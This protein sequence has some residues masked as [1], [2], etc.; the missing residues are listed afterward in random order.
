MADQINNLEPR[1]EWKYDI[2][3]QVAESPTLRNEVSLINE[4]ARFWI[5]LDLIR[6]QIENKESVLV[7][8]TSL[9]AVLYIYAKFM[10]KPDMLTELGK[11]DISDIDAMLRSKDAG[12]GVFEFT[13]WLWASKL[14]GGNRFAVNGIVDKSLT[15]EG[16][17]PEQ[18]AKEINDFAN[19]NTKWMI[20]KIVTPAD[21]RAAQSVIVNALYF[22]GAWQQQFDPKNTSTKPFTRFDWTKVDQEMMNRTLRLTPRFKASHYEAVQMNYKGG[23]KMIAILPGEW[24]SVSTV[25]NTLSTSWSEWLS[26][27][28]NPTAWSP[29]SKLEISF[30]KFTSETTLSDV[31]SRL[32]AAIWNQITGS[33]IVQ[34]TKIIVD[35]EWTTAAAVTG[36]VTRGFHLV[37]SIE[38]NKPFIYLLID[39]D[40]NVQF[41]WTYE[42][43][44][45]GKKL[46]V[47]WGSE[48]SIRSRH[49]PELD[50]KLGN[51]K[52]SVWNTSITFSG[53]PE[54]DRKIPFKEDWEFINIGNWKFFIEKATWVISFQQE[55]KELDLTGDSTPNEIANVTPVLVNGEVALKLVIKEKWSEAYQTYQLFSDTT[56]LKVK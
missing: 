43:P 22:K 35:E 9:Y 23:A 56:L 8:P 31:A 18:I 47:S 46:K 25:M 10:N 7:S 53:W 44:Q 39:P 37:D 4:Q 20:P 24:Q 32:P 30:P 3:L 36:M 55:G 41:V 50:K 48:E 38:F 15:T 28:L 14:S 51:I 17:T 2:P 13:N 40:N 11:T 54:G 27:L 49:S 34:K 52:F 16:K 19:T 1:N 21:V 12:S 5:T 26:S 29:P 6:K 45:W 33:A 42:W